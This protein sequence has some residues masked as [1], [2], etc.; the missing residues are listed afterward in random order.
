MVKEGGKLQRQHAASNDVTPTKEKKRK[1]EL[2]SPTSSVKPG[3]EQYMAVC[4]YEEQL[5]LQTSPENDM[6]AFLGVC[7]NL[8]ET[9]YKV[10]QLK[11]SG[12]VKPGERNELQK[13]GSLHILE[14]KRLTRLDK[15]R[16]KAA[17]LATSSSRQ[18]ADNHYLQLQ[19]LLYELQHLNK[20]ID[21]C[22]LF[23]SS[24]EDIDLVPLPE[25]LKNAPPEMTKKENDHQLRL[26]RL[27]FEL[28]E[29]KSLDQQ[30]KETD[31][32][33]NNI[34]Q[35]GSSTA[36][37]IN[38]L[39]PA[40]ST[41][42][43]ATLS[44]QTC[45]NMPLEKEREQHNM[46]RH[47]PA[48]LYVLYVQ[49]DGYSNASDPKLKVTVCGDLE[50]VATEEPISDK[51]FA[52][53][54]N[55]DE[56]D[57]D[58]ETGRE[59]QDNDDD[60]AKRYRRHKS[61]IERKK[62]IQNKVLTP[63]PLWVKMKLTDEGS[64]NL[65][66]KYHYIPY[67]H[68]VTVKV[69]NGIQGD[70]FHPQ[71][72]L[73]DLFN[74]DCG[75]VIPNPMAVYKLNDLG[76]PEDCVGTTDLG[77]PYNWVQKIAGLDFLEESSTNVIPDRKISFSNMAKTVKALRKRLNGRLE[78]HNQIQQLTDGSIPL[79]DEGR[80]ILPQRV[81]T[82]LV[83]WTYSNL[84]KFQR[85]QSTKLIITNNLVNS[86]Y[87]FFIVKLVCKSVKLTADVAVP[88]DYPS[89]APIWSLSINNGTTGTDLTASNSEVVRDIEA[90]VNVYWKDLAHPATF[91]ISHQAYHMCCCLDVY[92]SCADPDK[93]DK[94]YL[95]GKRGR[96]H[97]RPFKYLSNYN[98]F[99][100]R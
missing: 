64:G 18:K 19:N 73:S 71:T 65:V 53:Y 11:I 14:L 89:R 40:L 37:R 44:M 61:Q 79:S 67:L 32:D 13:T 55:D 48:P 96:S 74:A 78:L 85:S 98:L 7:K 3:A 22:L 9:M 1:K 39:P 99:T 8:E 2:S 6:K 41:I 17:R 33:I 20:E 35:A 50:A 34:L 66:L 43:N 80:K 81:I 4:Q 26:A 84:E 90:E 15:Y 28:D 75:T 62:E 31:E 72:L 92:T 76:L 52:D 29:R 57:S 82:S 68:I 59:R 93:V 24:D 54:F 27:Q 77:L 46:A 95:R 12:D 5:A 94:L 60:H 21:T 91:I 49:A 100:Q 70:L 38:S 42:L 47:L 45:L 97:A 63:H 56:S 25:F 83:S 88:P 51:S 87:S 58:T 23:K 69:D 16:L 30:C 86:N 36:D 10:R